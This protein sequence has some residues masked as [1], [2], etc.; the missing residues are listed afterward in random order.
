MLRTSDGGRIPVAVNEGAY[1]RLVQLATAN[2]TV[3]IQQLMTNGTVWLVQT[4]TRVQVIG[5]DWK[6]F[7]V[8]ILSGELAGRSGSLC[9][10]SCGRSG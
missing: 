9:A 7:E 8:R 10:I 2:D 3:G 4:G 5:T 1:D 6:R